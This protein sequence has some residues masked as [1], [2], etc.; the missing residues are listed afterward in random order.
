MKTKGLFWFLFVVSFTFII[1]LKAKSLKQ[2]ATVLCKSG[3]CYLRKSGSMWN[4]PLEENLI[5][6]VH[7]GDIV[8]GV[9]AGTLIEIIYEDGSKGY[10]NNSALLKVTPGTKEMILTQGKEV[11]SSEGFKTQEFEKE[12]GNLVYL[13]NVT[14]NFVT[15]VMGEPLI[16]NSFPTE[17]LIAFKLE[18][19][20]ESDSFDEQVSKWSLLNKE[21]LESKVGMKNLEFALSADK[22][23]FYTAKV[24]IEKAG[25][26]LLIPAAALN[27]NDKK[28]FSLLVRGKESIED[29]VKRLLMNADSNPNA[30]IE[31]RGK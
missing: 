19:K 8:I 12:K 4:L 26:Y 24:K 30:G 22:S 17:I 21:A 9:G 1:L 3:H 23:N 29:E 5:H 7:Y 31:I 20:S 14:V 6:E 13:G 27:E 2:K 18:G 25:E 28:G 15:P 16:F 10:L 11:A